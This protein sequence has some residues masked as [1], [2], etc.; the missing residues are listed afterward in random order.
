MAA[1]IRPVELIDKY[2]L[3]SA[4][5]RK[6]LLDHSRQVTKRA[7]KIARYRLNFEPVDLQFIA[8][9]AM[10]HDIG[11]IKTDTPDLGCH[12]S[13]PY[14]EHGIAGSKILTDEGLLQHAL[15][16]ERHIGIG[17]TAEEIRKQN[18]PLPQRDMKPESLEEKIICYADLFY[19]KSLNKRGKEKSVNEVRSSLGQFGEEKVAVFNQWLDLF[20]PELN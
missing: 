8:E 1:S 18:L 7:L 4:K 5:A 19:S 3:D 20:E 10:L 2:Y 13:R 17:L 16:C 14:L 9:A 11:I 6:I 12:G 15:V